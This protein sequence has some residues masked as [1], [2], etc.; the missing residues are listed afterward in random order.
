MQ[1]D[2]LTDSG[3]FLRNHYYGTSL[4]V[5]NENTIF[6]FLVLS[7]LPLMYRSDV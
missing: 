1:M 7:A 3:T 4:T 6:I 5:K 2:V